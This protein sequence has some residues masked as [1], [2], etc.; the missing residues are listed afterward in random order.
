MKNEQV[1]PEDETKASQRRVE[2][3]IC[4]FPHRVLA[5]PSRWA[6]LISSKK[7]GRVPSIPHLDFEEGQ[8]EKSDEI[9]CNESCKDE[10]CGDIP[11][12]EWAKTHGCIQPRLGHRHCIG[13]EQA[14]VVG[15]MFVA[16]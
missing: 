16:G 8:E 6:R 1:H 10:F 4:V 9:H 5:T 7:S 15:N 2:D 12:I 3:G 11:Q 14:E 13:R